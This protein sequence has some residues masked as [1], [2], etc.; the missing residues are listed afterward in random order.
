MFDIKNFY[1]SIKEKLLWEAIRFTKLC[2]SIT[3]NGIQA[4]CH[5]SKSLFYYNKE[6]LVKKG[7]SNFDVQWAHPMGQRYVN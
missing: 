3:K 1:P 4:I 7:E 5:A 2:I 6:P